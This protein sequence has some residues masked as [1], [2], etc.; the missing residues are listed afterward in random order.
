[1]ARI[2][3]ITIHKSTSYVISCFIGTKM[4]LGYEKPVFLRHAL[5]IIC[6]GIEK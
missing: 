3:K 5:S 4:P 1:M 2:T 6:V